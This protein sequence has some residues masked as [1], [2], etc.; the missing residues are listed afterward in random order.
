MRGFSVIPATHARTTGRTTG[1]A[2]KRKATMPSP[3][4]TNC[5]SL[6]LAA[7]AKPDCIAASTV[8]FAPEVSGWGVESASISGLP[9][10]VSFWRCIAYGRSG[11]PLSRDCRSTH[12]QLDG[13]TAAFLGG[14]TLLLRQSPVA[15]TVPPGP[16]R[17]LPA[18]EGRSRTGICFVGVLVSGLMS[19]GPIAAPFSAAA[20]RC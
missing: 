8:G 17:G 12:H 6:V 2:K 5:A 19:Y 1:R 9:F 18:R 4:R 15:A 14:I 20:G 11:S 3:T 10:T 7:I 16:T 13:S